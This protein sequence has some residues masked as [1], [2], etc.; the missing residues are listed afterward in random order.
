MRI[1]V[2]GPSGSGKSLVG[3]ALAARLRSPFVD[4]DDLHPRA[5]VAKMSAGTPLTDDDRA[6]WLA[7]VAATLARETSMVVACSALRRRYRDSIRAGVG[8]VI[9][10]EL[11]VAEAQ[12]RTRMRRREHFMPPSLLSSQLSLL[13][14]LATDEVGVRVANDA[15]LESVVSRIA[16]LLQPREA[17]QSRR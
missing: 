11:V 6:P 3:A 15:D 5:N 9:F 13:E 17:G 4:G 14:P 1:V 2:M 8:G 10:V 12:L 7:A 16:A